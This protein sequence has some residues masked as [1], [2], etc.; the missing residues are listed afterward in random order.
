[1]K[2]TALLILLAI[3]IPSAGAAEWPQWRGPNFNGSTDETN[4]PSRWSKTENVAWSA[5]L[6]GAGAGTPVVSGDRVFIS[7]T[8][9][10]EDVLKALCFDRTSGKLLWTRDVGKGTNKDYRSNYA[11]PSAATDGKLVVFFFGTGELVA[12]DLD[13]SKLWQRNIQKDFGPFAFLWTFSSSPLLYDGKLYMQILQRDVPVDG[14]GL[15]DRENESYLLALDPQTGK[16][17]WRHVRPSPAVRESR[18]AFSTPIPFTHEGREELLVIGGDVITGHD[19]ATGKELWRWG[20]WNPSKITHWR[21][22]PSPVAGGGVILACAPKMDPIYAVKAGGNGPLTDDD[23]AWVSRGDRQISADV[24][25]PAYY[26]GDF[27]ILSDVRKTLARVEPKTGKIKWT[28]RTPGLAK[29]EASPLAADGK[30]Y[31][32]NFV[33]EVTVVD[34]TSGDVINTIQMAEP[35]KDP[36]RSSVIAAGGQ[37]FIRTNTTLFCVGK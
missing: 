1:M 17:L 34:A 8:A 15:A 18:E 22:V 10:G 13:G 26:D 14:R 28:M 23:L 12:F 35:E 37:L 21:L 5:Q 24:P 9:P 6:P 32:I 19:P 20:T 27:F 16:L 3:T 29:Y 36:V 33:G 11:A 4:L 7:S 30:I 25:T 2:H 31:L